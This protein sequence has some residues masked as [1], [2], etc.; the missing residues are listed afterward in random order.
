[1]QR[2][3][4]L[5]PYLFCV[6]LSSLSA[7][8][9]NASSEIEN[10]VSHDFP[11]DPF[12]NTYENIEYVGLSTY[13]DDITA[14]PFIAFLQMR[15]NSYY[16]AIFNHDRFYKIAYHP[17]KIT[18]QEIKFGADQ[19]GY[20]VALQI[21]K[22]LREKIDNLEQHFGAYS[23]P[24]W[25]IIYDDYNPK[26]DHTEKPE[27]HELEIKKT[28]P[29]KKKPRPFPSLPNLLKKSEKTKNQLETGPNNHVP[30]KAEISKIK[31]KKPRPFPS[32]PN[33]LKKSEKTKN[34]SEHSSEEKS[35][36]CFCQ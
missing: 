26:C 21:S 36:P 17:E 2:Q 19:N 12:E 30:D 9:L 29:E 4:C 7:R 6:L 15:D 11:E 14:Y 10:R 25:I 24:Q 23:Y 16:L 13:Y 22:K 28:E 34:H 18:E 5:L 35:Q 31:K 20:I 33:L 27:I 8:Y 32:L 1:M 3:I